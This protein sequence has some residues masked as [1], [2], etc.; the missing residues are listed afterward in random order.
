[1]GEEDEDEEAGRGKKRPEDEEDCIL[2]I[3][4]VQIYCV[5]QGRRLI[6]WWEGEGRRRNILQLE[7][8]GRDTE[9]G[10]TW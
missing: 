4:V 2:S 6:N 8:T 10:K 7:R 5:V 3:V 1:M 9:S